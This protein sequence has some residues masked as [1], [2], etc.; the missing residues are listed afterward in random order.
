M[1]AQ[2]DSR[3]AKMPIGMLPDGSVATMDRAGCGPTALAAVANTVANR[4]VGYGQITPADIGAYAASNGYISQGGANA[5][6]FTEGASKLGL[7]SLP[8]ANASELKDN[9]LAG[10]PTILTGKSSNS[11]D[12]YTSAGHIVMADGLYGNKTRV[13]DP[14][15]GKHKLYD[16][17]N[18][19]KNTEHAWAYTAG[20][21]PYYDSLSA[22]D[23]EKAK[24]IAAGT[25]DITYAPYSNEYRE[26]LTGAAKEIKADP[27]IAFTT[28]SIIPTYVPSLTN[29]NATP[30]ITRTTVSTG[31]TT[32]VNLQPDAGIIDYGTIVG[33]HTEDSGVDTTILDNNY[34]YFNTNDKYYHKNYSIF[35]GDI[36]I[37]IC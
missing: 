19:S 20:Y 2:G 15:T 33:Y 5:G 3:W 26:K 4:A 23:K 18:I 37:P 9:L 7:N 35:F 8:I 32:L 12:P 30:S 17:D 36:Q 24:Q 1:Y 14:I 22:A 16:I 11:S 6:L 10:K 29:N 34:N 31:S 27:S 28:P 13:L 25:L 21:G